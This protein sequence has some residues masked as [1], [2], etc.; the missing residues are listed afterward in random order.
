MPTDTSRLR[1]PRE[2]ELWIARVR[3]A[4][5]C[6]AVLEVG[7]LS[8][9]YPP[10]Y[11]N[12]AWIATAVFAAGAGFL[13]DRVTF[14]FGVF[15]ITGAI[16]G[17]LVKRLGHEAALAEER[18]QE[19]ETLRD[20]LGR[21][22]DVLEAANRCA[23]ALASSLDLDQAFGAFIREL[24]GLIA[25]ERVT[26]VLVER[27]RAEV[28]AVAGRGT[29]TGFPPGS[30]RPVRGSALEEVLEGQL[31]YRASIAPP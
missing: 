20:E 1:R 17:W 31:V 2:V 14:P 3:L 16:V 12:Y 13:W 15:L 5:V 6:F 25:S 23:R 28:M 27:G 19:A 22:V 30:A 10:G 9:N 24:R 11:E 26:I 29:D 4:A 21:R 18:A 7:I 8:E